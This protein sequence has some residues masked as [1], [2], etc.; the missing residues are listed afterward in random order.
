MA[1]VRNLIGFVFI[2][3]LLLAFV[4]LWTMGK[5]SEDAPILSAEAATRSFSVLVET[6]G[7]LDAARSTVLFSQIRG[8]RGKIVWIIDDGA[9]IKKG[10]VL[11]RLDPTF[12]E[13]EVARLTAKVK[14]W[15][16]VVSAHEQM[17][18]WEKVQSEREIKTAEFDLRVAQL[19]LIKLEKGDGP[20][21]MGRLQGA[22]QEAKRDWEEK[23]GYLAD[24]K[25]LE[26]RGYANVTEITQAQNKV[27]E[28]KEAYEVAK[29][30]HESYRDYVLP[31]SKENAQAQVARAQ[32]NLEQLKKGSGFKIG[33]ALAALRKAQQSLESTTY[34]LKTAKTELERT[35]IRAPIPGISVLTEAFYGG[36]KRKPRIGDIVWQNQALVYLP[37]ISEMI[38]KANIREIDLHKVGVGKNAVVL[39]DAY[40][41]LRLPGQVQSI[42]VLAESEA[43]SH[44]ADKYFQVVVSV[45]KEDQRLRPGM[46]ARVEIECTKITNALCVP[47]HA[48]FNEQGKRYV[49]VDTHASYEK[50]E[51]SIGAQS[52]DW[53]QVLS[54]LKEGECVA[55]S[56]PRS[57][58]ILTGHE[59][60]QQED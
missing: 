44:T 29:R 9:R 33:K 22:A 1:R 45:L 58:E 28:A 41:D 25:T 46:T 55:L 50:R 51:V 24:L 37:D 16:V 4:L 35:V 57:S 38:V 18:E 10:D 49:Y 36:K 52:E 53:A 43:E 13:E 32:M 34:S 21:E 26:K 27:S 17:L 8:D 11:V 31:S 60:A 40:P 59:R 3:V 54:G 47:I 30:Q 15:E 48:V 7:E 6:V 42:G 39:V 14:E 5:R 56:R 19:D 12:F 20:L 2:P 23:K